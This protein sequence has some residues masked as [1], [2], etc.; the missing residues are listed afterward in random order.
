MQLAKM[1]NIE[2]VPSLLCLFIPIHIHWTPLPPLKKK[3][4]YFVLQEIK[5]KCAEIDQF[6]KWKT[7]LSSYQIRHCVYV[8]DGVCVLGGIQFYIAGNDARFKTANMQQCCTHM[9]LLMAKTWKFLIAR[10]KFWPWFSP[11]ITPYT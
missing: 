7:Y 3:R 1:S 4:E 10:S 8:S 2:I 5:K 6:N 11:Y 9:L